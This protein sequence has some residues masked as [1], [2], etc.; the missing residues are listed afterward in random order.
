MNVES[1]LQWWTDVH[2]SRRVVAGSLQLRTAED[3]T[4]SVDQLL[5][6]LLGHQD[7]VDLEAWQV[8]DAL[9]DA[10][11]SDYQKRY[12]LIV[13]GAA[14]Q[15]ALRRKLVLTNVARQVRPFAGSKARVVEPW[16]EDE[17]R[18]FLGT[19]PEVYRV[20]YLLA[21]RPAEV[22]GLT[23]AEVQGERVRIHQQLRW[24]RRSSWELCSTKG[25]D[26]IMLPL[27]RRARM[28]LQEACRRHP[29]G[30]IFRNRRGKPWRNQ[31]YNQYLAAVLERL[32]LAPM[33]A[34]GLR[35]QAASHLLNDGVP[36]VVVSKLLRHSS[37]QVTVDTYGHL[38]RAGE[39]RALE[40]LDRL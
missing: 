6:P 26:D 39:D 7:L 38:S 21:L 15:E 22:Q 28:P 5:V 17:T 30:L 19:A 4:R 40:A 32:G 1:H 37:I 36:V 9:A 10:D 27:P 8:E 2:L 25:R 3:Y 35:H 11:C 14:L 12:A 33:T 29:E 34:H 13:L 23:S 20:Q 24:P 18:R 31:A 16:T